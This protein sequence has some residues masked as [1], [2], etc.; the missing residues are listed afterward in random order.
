MKQE[1]DLTRR[2]RLKKVDR[3]RK[4]F[5]CFG[6]TSAGALFVFGVYLK[7]NK[8]ISLILALLT[9]GLLGLAAYLK[10]FIRSNGGL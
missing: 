4:L 6:L 5:L 7:V 1:N 2:E 9:V 3:Y 8:V 10:D